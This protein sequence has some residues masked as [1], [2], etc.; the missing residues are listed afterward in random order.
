MK[1]SLIKLFMAFSMVLTFAG[2][3]ITITESDPEVGYSIDYDYFYS[4]FCSDDRD[5]TTCKD[6]AAGSFVRVEGDLIKNNRVIITAKLPGELNP[7]Y[8]EEFYYEGRFSDDDGS[9]YYF[10]SVDENLGD[11]FY[12]YD[13]DFASL[14]NKY[15]PWSYNFSNDP[16]LYKKRAK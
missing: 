16:D 3:T 9:Y 8:E 2:C 10:T 15:E 14:E 7:N 4:S 13:G 5:D 12:I 6:L 11:R 1:K